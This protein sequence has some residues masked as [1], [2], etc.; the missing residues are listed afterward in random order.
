MCS[1]TSISR[2]LT[3]ILQTYDK[4]NFQPSANKRIV[5]FKNQVGSH[6]RLSLAMGR[7]FLRAC[8]ILL[9]TFHLAA[10]TTLTAEGCRTCVRLPR[11]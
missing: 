2:K 5:N 4:Y 9:R 8:K 11:T 7:S 3:L 1:S 6:S 10:H